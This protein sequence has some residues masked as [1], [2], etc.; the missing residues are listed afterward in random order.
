MQAFGIH[1]YSVIETTAGFIELKK[2][3]IGDHLY[4]VD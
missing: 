1:S 2:I 4:V 3:K